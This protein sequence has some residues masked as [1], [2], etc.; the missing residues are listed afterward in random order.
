VESVRSGAERPQ[1]WVVKD[2][3]RLRKA[4]IKWNGQRDC[5]DRPRFT[6]VGADLGKGDCIP[7]P[8]P[9]PAYDF[10]QPTRPAAAN[11][12]RTAARSVRAYLTGSL[13]RAGRA[14]ITHGRGSAG[15]GELRYPS[16]K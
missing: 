16:A 1:A 7:T 12:E 8:A 9:Q 2:P 3:Q 11:V 13:E 5:A 4:S 10:A 6:L 15:N 14:M